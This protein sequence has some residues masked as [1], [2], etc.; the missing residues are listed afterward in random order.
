VDPKILKGV[1][2]KLVILN[3][4]NQVVKVE[5]GWV[6]Q[7]LLS[8]CQME[9]GCQMSKHPT[10]YLLECMAYS[11]SPYPCLQSCG[12]NVK[13]LH[14]PGPSFNKCRLEI[15]SNILVKYF[16]GQKSSLRVFAP[17]K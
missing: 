8:S 17:R 10:G 13:V 6:E 15:I 2:A 12:Q 14:Q 3:F 1:G 7:E 9:Q 16:F 4:Y 11:S 5:E